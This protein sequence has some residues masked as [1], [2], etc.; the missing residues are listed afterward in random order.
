MALAASSARTP[1]R[2]LHKWL[3]FGLLILA[4]RAPPRSR[5]PGISKAGSLPVCHPAPFQWL[6]SPY[7][8]LLLANR[9]PHG[10]LMTTPGTGWGCECRDWCLA[11]HRLT[12]SSCR[13]NG[14]AILCSLVT[15][16]FA[17]R[18]VE[19]G[20]QVKYA[21]GSQ[22]SRSVRPS[23]AT[24]HEVRVRE[25]IRSSAGTEEPIWMQH[26]LC[27]G[28]DV[29]CQTVAACSCLRQTRSYTL[30]RSNHPNRSTHSVLNWLSVNYNVQ[31]R[32]SSVRALRTA[33][34]RLESTDVRKCRVMQVA[35]LRA[36][37]NF[38][39]SF[40]Y[41]WSVVCVY[42][43]LSYFNQNAPINCHQK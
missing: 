21:N 30:V 27:A 18:C 4:R 37:V 6:H 26:V 38:S 10:L 25:P 3:R 15:Y 43:S 42:S 2:T 20:W 23:A 1:L 36:S 16:I 24:Q 13:T 33:E 39:C 40:H 28:S 12:I 11:P 31:K 34:G 22:W 19:E 32:G 29:R 8:C 41:I 35:L 14:E 5:F 17:I 7:H 9:S